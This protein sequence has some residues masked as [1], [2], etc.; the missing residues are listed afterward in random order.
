MTIIVRN[1]T[2][3]DDDLAEGTPGVT[4]VDFAEL[5]SDDAPRAQT[6]AVRLPNSADPFVAME[7]IGGVAAVAIPFPAF[8]DGRGF[9]LARWLRR[10]GFK[11]RLR[12]HGT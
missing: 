5:D 4:W 6:L 8:S 11:G 1:G 7:K 3:H 9:G 2:F 10:L 12:A